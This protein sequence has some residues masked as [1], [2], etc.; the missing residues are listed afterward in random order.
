MRLAARI[1]A[2]RESATMRHVAL[3]WALYA[4][5][6]ALVAATAALVAL[7]GAP[8]SQLFVIAAAG[9][10]TAGA[11]IAARRPRNAVGWLL[12]AV[13]IAFAVNGL[14]EAY[15]A[16]EA[17]PARVAVAWTG[18][19]TWHIWLVLVVLILPLVFPTGRLLSPRWRGGLMVAAAALVLSAASDAFSPGRIDLDGGRPFDNPLAAHGALE[20]VRTFVSV[21][22]SVAYGLGYAL[23]ALALVVRFRRA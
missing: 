13:G 3:A 17:N 6:V 9:F 7:Q 19:W 21:L 14:L 11:L 5:F 22:G 1:S 15:A 4:V 12:L 2:R 16:R 18:N 23:A 8:A 10:P 20:T